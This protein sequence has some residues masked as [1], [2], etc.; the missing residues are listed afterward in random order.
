LPSTLNPYPN[1]P[2]YEGGR[3]DSLSLIKG[4]VG[5]G[6]KDGES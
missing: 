2:P 6:V 5:E 3:P 4:R 1:L